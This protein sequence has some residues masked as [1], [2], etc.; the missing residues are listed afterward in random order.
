MLLLDV[1]VVL[2]VHVIVAQTPMRAAVCGLS[3]LRTHA[4]RFRAPFA[5]AYE[6]ERPTQEQPVAK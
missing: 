1:G 5:L 4:S 3:F 2:V 6:S